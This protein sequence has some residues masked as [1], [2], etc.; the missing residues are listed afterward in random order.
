C[1]PV[2]THLA[3]EDLSR[4][5]P[6]PLPPFTCPFQNKQVLDLVTI[7]N[8]F[9]NIGSEVYRRCRFLAGDWS[10]LLEH[11]KEQC[12]DFILTSETIYSSATYQ[13]LIEIFK[14]SLK[15]HGLMYP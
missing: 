11:L 1:K 14:K 4:L 6:P 10:V 2:L 15:P 5:T 13:D 8:A 12:Y 3:V 9:A 7:P